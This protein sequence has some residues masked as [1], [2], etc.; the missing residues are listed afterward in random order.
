MAANEGREVT[1]DEMIKL[2]QSY[3]GEI[4]LSKL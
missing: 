2:K 1:W 3:K 4:D